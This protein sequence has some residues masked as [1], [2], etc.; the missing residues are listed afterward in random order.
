LLWKD[1]LP[2]TVVTGSKPPLDGAVETSLRHHLMDHIR[3]LGL[4]TVG[5]LPQ[6]IS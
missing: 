4:D 5:Y 3:D 6:K 2:F 1:E